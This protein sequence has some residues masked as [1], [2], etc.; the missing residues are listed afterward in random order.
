MATAIDVGDADF[1]REVVERSR[2]LPVVVDFWAEWC[3][4]CRQLAP[5]LEQLAAEHEGQFVLAKV[6]V[7]ANPVVAQQL[8]VRSIPLVLGFRDG[9]VV[10]EFTGAQPADVVR[11]FL[12]QLLPT[13]ADELADEGDQLAADGHRRA[14]EERYRAALELEPR[15]GAALLGLARCLAEDGDLE[16]A[17]ELVARVVPT[18][19][20]GHEAERM[21]AELR[22]RGE[23]ASG[24]ESALRARIE[25]EPGDL[26]ARLDLGRTLAAAGRHEEALETLLEVVRRDADFDEEGA[27]RAMLDLFE[28]LG[29]DHPLTARFRRELARALFK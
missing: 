4:P 6:D 26:A 7:D 15:H 1:G 14:A 28:V 22:T 21:A 2:D 25:A 18:G 20:L 24:D 17:Q 5:V 11:R 23:G 19:E 27:R 9:A 13:Q 10:A 3:G 8:G 16:E 12:A 29:A